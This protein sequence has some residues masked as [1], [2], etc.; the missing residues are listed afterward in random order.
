VISKGRV[1]GKAT[2][3]ILSSDA[4]RHSH[5]NNEQLS[6][7]HLSITLNF[8]IG[9]KV[10]DERDVD[11][12]KHRQPRETADAGTQIDVSNGQPENA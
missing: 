9:S 6:N 3:V 11:L 10:T 8:D 2:A 1:T 7:A 12:E 4:G 5:F